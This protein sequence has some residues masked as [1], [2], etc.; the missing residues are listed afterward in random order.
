MPLNTSQASIPIAPLLLLALDSWSCHTSLNSSVPIALQKGGSVTAP[1]RG[2]VTGCSLNMARESC[3]ASRG[4]TTVHSPSISVMR[5]TCR[6]TLKAALTAALDIDICACQNERYF[7][8]Q[9][10]VTM[11]LHMISCTEVCV[12]VSPDSKTCRLSAETQ[13]HA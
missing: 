3:S 4:S 7:S 9:L 1:V 10:H 13:D 11:R 5:K 12:R 8:L 2:S 6:N